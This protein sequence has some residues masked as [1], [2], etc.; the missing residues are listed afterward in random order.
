MGSPR[1]DLLTGFRKKILESTDGVRFPEG[2]GGQVCLDGKATR[3]LDIDRNVVCDHLYAFSVNEKELH[4]LC[5]WVQPKAFAVKGLRTTTLEPLKAWKD[6]AQLQLWWVQK[7]SDLNPLGDLTGLEVLILED[8][9]RADDLSFLTSLTGLRALA[10]EGGMWNKRPIKTLEPLTKL[11]L[12]EE[13]WLQS[14]QIGEG[15]LR[16]IAQCS[17]LQ[18]LNVSAN[19]QTEDYAYLRAHCPDLNCKSLQAWVEAPNTF[20]DKDVMVMG[21]RKPFLNKTKD[22]AKIA[23]YEAAF[24][25]MVEEFSAE[26]RE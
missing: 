25:K 21:H 3:I 9:K 6:L 5:T 11:S 14:L 15:G 7:L 18:N 16:P 10:I 8:I 23:K 4:H 17:G 20:G 24:A 26:M 19:F 12:L 1:F 13:L 2:A 22:A